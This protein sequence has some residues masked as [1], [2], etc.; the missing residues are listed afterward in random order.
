MFCFIPGYLFISLNKTT[1]FLDEPVD[2]DNEEINSIY[3]D[4]YLGKK[5]LKIQSYTLTLKTYGQ[6]NVQMQQT[7]HKIETIIEGS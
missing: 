7:T 6:F 4:D 5:C 3:F 1:I 2:N